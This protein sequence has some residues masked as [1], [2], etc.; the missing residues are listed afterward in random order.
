VIL[1]YALHPQLSWEA[2]MGVNKTATL[3]LRIE[4]SIKEMLR[5]VAQEEHRSVANMIEVMILDYCQRRGL[6]GNG[7]TKSERQ[8]K[9]AE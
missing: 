3:T 5:V 7:S 2:V 4:P 6:P 1:Q 8:G 9:H